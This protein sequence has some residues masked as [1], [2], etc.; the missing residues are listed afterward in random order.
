M[1]FKVGKFDTQTTGKKQE[2]E[3]AFQKKIFEIYAGDGFCGNLS[4]VKPIVLTC[5]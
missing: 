3:Y 1:I 5:D 2:A 4:K